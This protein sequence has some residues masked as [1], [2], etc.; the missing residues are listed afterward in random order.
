MI[1]SKDFLPANSDGKSNLSFFHL[2]GRFKQTCFHSICLSFY[3]AFENNRKLFDQRRIELWKCR[4]QKSI[5][6]RI[7]SWYQSI[8]EKGRNIFDL[9]DLPFVFS[10]NWNLY[11]EN[12]L[13]KPFIPFELEI[14]RIKGGNANPKFT[15]L[16]GGW[17]FKWMREIWNMFRWT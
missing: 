15:L 17:I 10:M 4:F 16:N 7:F 13:S 11:V 3:L 1:Q 2:F 8:K 9:E 6:D 14:P 12:N 5:D